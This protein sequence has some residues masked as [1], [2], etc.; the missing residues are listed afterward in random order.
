[1][2][3]ARTVTVRAGERVLAR[4]QLAPRVSQETALRGVR[5]EPGDTVWTFETDKPA[6][7]PNDYDRRRVAF[8]LRDLDLKLVGPAP[9][10]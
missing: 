2:N 9:T 6:E 8:S 7:F 10:K 3:D 5:L 4:V 1:A